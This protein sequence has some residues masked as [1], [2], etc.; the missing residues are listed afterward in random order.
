MKP[1]HSP[2]R[3]VFAIAFLAAA[4]SSG[5]EATRAVAQETEF[6]VAVLPFT[7]PDDGESKDVQEAMIAGLDLL[8]PY[9]LIEQDVINDALDNA[10]LEPGQEI[11]EAKTL[12]IG[13]DLGAKIVARGKLSQSGEQWTA[14]PVFVEVGTRVTQELG[15]VTANDAS[16]LGERVVESFNSRN[17]ADKHVIFGRDYARSQAYGRAL[18]NFKQALEFDPELA[19]AY[20]YMGTTYLEM[21]SLN[22]ALASLQKAVEIDPAYINAYLSIGQAYLEKGDT[23]QA[24]GFFEELAAQK[25]DDC[26]IQVAYGY[27][28]ANQLGEVD[29]GLQAFEKAKQLCPDNAEAYQYLA[30]ALPDTRREE[31]IQNFRKY[32][33]LT[34]GK[35]TD[36]EALQY[37]FGL[38]LAEEQFT[39]AA[40]TIEQALAADP[41][42]ASLQLY[43]GIAQSKLGNHQQ[44]IPYFDKA[45]ELNPDLQDAYLYR[46]IS[47]RELGNTA[48]YAQDLERA[49]QGQSG[50]ILAGLALADAHRALQSGRASA[51]LEA[52]SRAS[53]LGANSCAVSYYRGDAFYRMGRGLEGEDSTVAQNERAKEMFQTAINH[54]QGACGE[55][56]GYAQG[57]INNANQYIVRVD[58]IIRKLSSS[59]G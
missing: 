2:S 19:R 20:Y 47:N 13:R 37:L 56:Q 9:T 11:P 54:L 21:D 45:I 26:Q 14:E 7:S 59:G 18:T 4:L 12:E 32:L 53:A 52:L 27:V 38:Y 50:E 29:K 31:K 25:A 33:E 41:T 43:A 44:A 22:P 46:A 30:Y 51:A 40:Q 16:D 36:P 49:G 3:A 48:A 34:E 39:E 23:T 6:V 28:M 8:G 35:A 58:A 42:N 5:F 10:G 1:T 57:L 24:K 17:Q 55:Y 15:P